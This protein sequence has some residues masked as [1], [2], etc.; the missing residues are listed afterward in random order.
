MVTYIQEIACPWR[1]AFWE[2]FTIYV[3]GL[4][5][6]FP[7]RER[8]RLLYFSKQQFSSAAALWCLTFLV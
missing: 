7:G 2:N 4:V 1:K 8:R 3:V 6:V 5:F